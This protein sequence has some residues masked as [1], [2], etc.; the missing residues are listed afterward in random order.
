MSRFPL[1]GRP[2]A[3]CAGAVYGSL[4]AASV[5]VTAGS[6]GGYPRLRLVLLLAVTGLVF[7]AAHV[8]ARLVGERAAGRDAGR[9]A[10]RT[11]AAHEWP[12]VQAAALPAAAVAVGALLGLD[13]RATGW[14]ALGT[15]VAQQV[16]WATVGAAR[17]GA[18]RPRMLAEALVHLALGLVLVSVKAVVTH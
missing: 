18:T 1:P 13:T 12:I 15:A 8:Y 9:R 2:G 4:L 16:G 11:A 10:L 17:T 6:V 7:W 3:D 14:L 5:V